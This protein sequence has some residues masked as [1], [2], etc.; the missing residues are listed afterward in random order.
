MTIAY[1]ILAHSSF[2]HL[3]RL[4]G[5]IYNASDLFIIHVD[6]KAPA[7]MHYGVRAISHRFDNVHILASEMCSWG[8]FSLVEATISGLVRA[9]ESSPEWT[10]L[11]LLSESH[12]PL[13]HNSEIKSSL[14]PDASYVNL[15]TYAQFGVGGKSDLMSRCQFKYREL[16]GVG[17]FQTTL[18]PSEDVSAR[19]AKLAHGSQWIIL[20]RNAA[21]AVLEACRE[22]RFSWLR[23]VLIPDE[24]FFHTILAHLVMTRSL[25]VHNK[26]PTY[27]ANKC[28]G[29]MKSNMNFDDEDFLAAQ[30]A[31]FLYIRKTP[32]LVPPD[33]SAFIASISD[34]DIT[35]HIESFSDVVI[36]LNHQLPCMRSVG[37]DS[38]RARVADLLADISGNRFVDCRL[39]RF[40]YTPMIDFKMPPPLNG[41][42]QTSLRIL[43]EDGFLFKFI[44]LQ[45]R[46]KGC[47]V[48]CQYAHEFRRSIAKPRVY[49]VSRNYEISPVDT[50]THGFTV[51]AVKD[52]GLENKFA[53]TCSEY[54]DLMSQVSRLSAS[55]WRLS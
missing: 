28:N 46:G 7:S 11:I 10:H 3:G 37:V 52:L 55:D 32:S 22:E 38:T 12:L 53:A 17:P 54:I 30:R 16:P 15:R 47:A 4:I 40:S 21:L 31:G 36:E 50:L 9:C 8:G 25:I 51:L 41:D 27:L 35:K 5:A 33:V 49:G 13:R 29:R 39:N 43:S 42:R 14:E 1:L 24:L 48:P 20:S 6:T 18:L 45:K 23:S 26:M 2:D 34:L 19:L 44:I